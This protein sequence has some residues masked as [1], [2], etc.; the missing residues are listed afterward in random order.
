MPNGPFVSLHNHTEQG[1]PLDGMNDVGLLFDKAKE[2]DH[3][4]IAITDHGTMTAHYDAYKAS[5]KTGVKLIPGMEAYFAPDLSEKKSNH[6]VLVPKTEKGYKNILRLN[7]EAYN[8]QA[9][10]YMGKLTPRISWEHIAKFNEDVFCLTA[11][12]N[13]VLSRDIVQDRADKAEENVLKLKSIFGD[14]LF[15]RFSH[16]LLKQMMEM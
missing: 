16:M 11:C 6:M 13:G 8:N 10:G 1:S 5:Q 2:L 9:S 12:S 4:A 7:Y 15:W 14:R 3:P